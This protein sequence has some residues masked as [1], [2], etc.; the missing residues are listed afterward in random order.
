MAWTCSADGGGS[1]GDGSA[2]WTSTAI[3]PTVGS[4]AIGAGAAN[5]ISKLNNISVHL[6]SEGLSRYP[7]HCTAPAGGE[8]NQLGPVGRASGQL[9]ERRG[10]SPTCSTSG[11]RPDARP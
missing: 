11:S 6:R 10:V 3:W 1:G 9:G 5:G 4:T 7:E 8:Q 2:F